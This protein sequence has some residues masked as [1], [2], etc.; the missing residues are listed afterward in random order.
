ML[1][2]LDLCLL[3]G[4]GSKKGTLLHM[5]RSKKRISNFI[6][7]LQRVSEHSDLCLFGGGSLYEESC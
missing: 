1:Q 6:V 2:A 3:F 4:L 5:K 7:L